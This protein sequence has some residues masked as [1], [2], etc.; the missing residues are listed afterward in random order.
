MLSFFPW[1]SP[2]LLSKVKVYCKSSRES[3][4][5]YCPLQEHENP[6]KGFIR[7]SS[8]QRRAAVFTPGI[9]SLFLIPELHTFMNPSVIN[10]GIIEKPPNCNLTAF[11]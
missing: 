11:M 4:D 1:Y 3:L 6:E 10:G 9:D 5:Q 2:E 7:R 8:A